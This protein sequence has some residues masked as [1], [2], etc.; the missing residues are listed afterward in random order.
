MSRNEEAL[1]ALERGG[2]RRVENKRCVKPALIPVHKTGGMVSRGG[3]ANAIE[4]GAKIYKVF[5]KTM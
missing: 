4:T 3:R 2:R 1:C 5:G